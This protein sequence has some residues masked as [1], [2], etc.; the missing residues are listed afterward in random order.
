MSP[1][2]ARPNFSQRR[3]LLTHERA[4]SIMSTTENPKVEEL[5]TTV[6]EAADE[7]KACQC[8]QHALCGSCATT[9]DAEAPSKGA[10][11]PSGWL[12]RLRGI[13]RRYYFAAAAVVVVAVGAAT[14]IRQRSLPKKPAVG[15]LHKPS[16]SRP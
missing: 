4:H 15:P 6:M 3:R 8:V 1:T 10:P 14:F 9:D 13:R 12:A 11:A 5:P 7:A 16:Y 2:A